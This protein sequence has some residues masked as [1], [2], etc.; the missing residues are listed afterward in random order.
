MNPMIPHLLWRLLQLP[1]RPSPP[2]FQETLP[3]AVGTPSV[4]DII[5]GGNDPDNTP[6]SLPNCCDPLEKY[7]K[8]DMPWAQIH[9]PTSLYDNIDVKTVKRWWNLP[10]NKLLAI[11]FDSEVKNSEL[12]KDIKGCILAAVAK[13]TLSTTASV[14]APMPSKEA[15]HEGC[16]PTSFI[17]YNISETHF[18][19]LLEHHVWA[20]INF[21]FHVAPLEP[22]CP[23]FLFTIKGFATLKNSMV[24]KTITSAWND[25]T[26]MDFIQEITREARPLVAL[27]LPLKSQ[28]ILMWCVWAMLKGGGLLVDGQT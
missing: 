3:P 16:T 12:Y 24:K 10:G 20:S 22:A 4:R 14:A 13:I 9:H 18:H 19:I 7:T 21:T 6:S 5:T 2:Q 15:I 27:I 28:A 1:K 25:E 26:T 17:I 8:G 11:P 23:D